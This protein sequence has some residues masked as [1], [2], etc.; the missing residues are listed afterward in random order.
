MF[1]EDIGF[2][3][4]PIRLHVGGQRAIGSF[5]AGQLG[6][7]GVRNDAAVKKTKDQTIG[8]IRRVCLIP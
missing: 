8:L 1:L 7:S 6:V 3:R 2:F 5:Q 4:E